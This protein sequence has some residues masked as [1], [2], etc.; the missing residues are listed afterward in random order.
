[1]VGKLVDACR[2]LEEIYWRQS[3]PDGLMLY[4]SLSSATSQK[5]R[6]LRRFLWING[7][8]FDLLGENSPFVWAEPM[9]PGRGFYSTGIPVAQVE[10]F[11]KQHPEKREAIYSSTTILRWHGDDLEAVPYHIAYRSFLEPAAK[12]L[13]EAAA[14]SSDPAFANFLRLR[15]DALLSDDYFK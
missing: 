13:R 15:A 2:Y 10:N 14:L 5:D 6:Q 3:D 9:P 8:G 11:V 7:G 12:D 1:M 4:E